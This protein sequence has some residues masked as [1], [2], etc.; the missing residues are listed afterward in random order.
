MQANERTYEL[1]VSSPRCITAELQ[2]HTTSQCHRYRHRLLNEISRE[3][4]LT[5]ELLIDKRILCLSEHVVHKLTVHQ[6]WPPDG[7]KFPIEVLDALRTARILAAH[8]TGRIL[9]VPSPA[10]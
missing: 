4:L 10:N 2:G 3:P 9:P 8:V 7:N 6:D 1:R 5:Y